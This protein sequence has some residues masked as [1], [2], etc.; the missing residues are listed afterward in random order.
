[1]IKGQVF[2]T[3]GAGY[4]GRS[5]IRKAIR[6]GWDS[7][8]TVY[9]RD[10]TK[11]DELQRKYGR[12]IEIRCLLGDIG[13]AESLTRAMAGHQ[14]VLHM[15][16]VKYIPDAERNR[17]EAVKVNVIGSMNVITAAHRAGVETCIGISTDKAVAPVNTYGATKYQ[18]EGLFA[19]AANRW[20]GTGYATCRYGN[21]VGSTGSVIPLFARQ[22]RDDRR[23][24]V[25]DPRMSRFWLAPDDAC[26][27]I[28]HS[29]QAASTFRGAVFVAACPSMTIGDLAQAVILA[30]ESDVGVDDVEVLEVGIRPGEKLS[31]DLL[32]PAECPRSVHWM[33]GYA[34]LEY[35]MRERLFSAPGHLIP[36][37]YN[38][39]EPTSWVSVATMAGWIQDARAI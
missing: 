11:Q 31:E 26:Q 22:I 23:I 16:A 37:P 2:M 15:A 1:M 17:W 36:K 25:T 7:T 14:T 9:S 4:L 29:A 35:G 18:M 10:E 32:A 24:T 28:E 20:S 39:A 3:G 27:L 34:V 33:N 12:D 6:E 38:S 30:D 19:E 8:F 21:V 13:D 5:V